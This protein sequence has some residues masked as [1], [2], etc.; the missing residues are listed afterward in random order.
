MNSTHLQS[1]NNQ[2]FFITSHGKDNSNVVNRGYKTDFI[3]QL[4][5]SPYNATN[6]FRRY[7][8]DKREYL[9]EE[10]VHR[11]DQ[12]FTDL[13]IAAQVDARANADRPDVKRH[14][15]LAPG[16]S[17]NRLGPITLNGYSLYNSNSVFEFFKDAYLSFKS[18]GYAESRLLVNHAFN[19]PHSQIIYPRPDYKSELGITDDRAQI[20]NS[21]LRLLVDKTSIDDF[22]LRANSATSPGP[23]YTMREI[24]FYMNEDIYYGNLEDIQ[25]NFIEAL[26]KDYYVVKSSW[27]PEIERIYFDQWEFVPENVNIDNFLYYLLNHILICADRGY[28]F[29]SI[30]KVLNPDDV[31]NP[32]FLGVT[33]DRKYSYIDKNGYH[34]GTIDNLSL[35]KAAIK[36]TKMLHGMAVNRQRL[37]NRAGWVSNSASMVITKMVTTSIEESCNSFASLRPK[38][39]DGYKEF[40]RVCAM[41]GGCFHFI[42]GDR[43]NAETFVTS[44][45]DEFIRLIPPEWHKLY[46]AQCTV[47]MYGP[48]YYAYQ[49]LPSGIAKTTELNWIMGTYEAINAISKLVR[50]SFVSVAEAY[51]SSVLNEVPYFEINGYI[52]KLF[53]P[54]DDI[55]LV[56]YGPRIDNVVKILGTGTG[57]MEWACDY[58]EMVTF[59]MHFSAIELKAAQISPIAKFFYDE[60]PG[61]FYKSC[62]SLIA[63]YDN[64]DRDVKT[65]ANK[66]YKKHF[67]CDINEF[68]PFAHLYMSWLQSLGIKLEDIFDQYSPSNKIIYSKY[69]EGDPMNQTQVVPKQ[70]YQG[71]FDHFKRL[72]KNFLSKNGGK[73]ITNKNKEAHR[74]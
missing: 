13:E 37:I 44:N 49:G 47:L 62:F 18:I 74:A 14:Y 57:Q 54:T 65:L 63:K 30:D 42:N 36:V 34:Y 61:F 4:G 5:V 51:F 35:L 60:H 40:L 12:R 32:N 72:N 41:R 17:N 43:S 68:R 8:I 52:I 73:M 22:D 71:V 27:F 28:R 24:G 26:K 56:I 64:A 21:F 70:Y 19:C 53:M 15:N 48:T 66:L 46:R 29:N 33:K 55:P 31:E 3:T 6:M 58:T 16:I 45:F 59:G 50:A 7:N 39:L 38:V 11:T 20:F 23:P 1:K 67:N 10:G 25:S 2:K 69:V 9:R